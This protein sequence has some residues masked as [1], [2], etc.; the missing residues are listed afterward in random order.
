MSI[1]GIRVRVP[2]CYRSFGSKSSPE[3]TNLAQEGSSIENSTKSAITI[4]DSANILKNEYVKVY[5]KYKA[6]CLRMKG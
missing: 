4:R 2:A 3:V 1:K 5:R 6:P